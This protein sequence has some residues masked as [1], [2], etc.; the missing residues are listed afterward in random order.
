M[1]VTILVKIGIQNIM[2][3]DDKTYKNFDYKENVVEKYGKL[4]S[5]EKIGNYSGKIKNI[6]EQIQKSEGIVLIYS[7]Y[8]DGGCLPLALALENIGITRY[9]DS[10]KSLFKT[11]QSQQLNAYTMKPL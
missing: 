7:Q 9:G 10:K 8:I 1:S 5:P 6:L 11:S 4:F 2:D 3:Y